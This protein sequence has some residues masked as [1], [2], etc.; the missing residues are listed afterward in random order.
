MVDA[1]SFGVNELR[2]RPADHRRIILLISETR[3]N[4]SEGKL[5]DALIEAE[6][7]NV[8]IYTVNIDRAL[9][10][11]TKT[12]RVQKNSPFPAAANPMPGGGGIM[13]PTPHVSEQLN[14]QQSMTFVPLIKEV[15]IQTKSLFVPN[16]A[17]DLHGVHG[18]PGIRFHGP[19]EPGVC[20]DESGRGTAQPIHPQLSAE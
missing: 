9:A 6:I 10:M 16:K 12:P 3:D 1:V 13:P 19:Q 20:T 11:L 5:R 2:K 14:G 15:F 4:G 7:H 8:I 17:E 18:R